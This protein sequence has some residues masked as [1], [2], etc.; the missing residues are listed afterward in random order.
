MTKE[1]PFIC[2]STG[3]MFLKEKIK[4]STYKEGY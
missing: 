3:E 2:L 1:V 4:K